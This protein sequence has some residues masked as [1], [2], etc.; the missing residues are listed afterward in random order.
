MKICVVIVPGMGLCNRLKGLLT[1]M[2]KAAITG[3]TFGLLWP[4]DA[5]VSCQF[6]DLFDMPV[7]RMDSPGSESTHITWRFWVG[8]NEIPAGWAQAYPS[9]DVDGRA[10]DFEY[11]RIPQGVRAAYLEQLMH[12]RPKV[13][14]LRRAQKTATGKFVS[15]HIRDGEDW[16]AWG[17]GVP[18]ENFFSA[19]DRCPKETRFFVSAHTLETVERIC[20]R[21]PG[22]VMF[23]E[24]KEYSG[25]TVR[26]MQDALADLLCLSGGDELIG[27]Y[28]S[29]F[30]EM[31]WWF[32]C[33][34][35]RVTIVKGDQSKFRWF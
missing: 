19:M 1:V 5:G 7:E 11:E 23:Q 28:G 8:K 9:E 18:L 24:G 25:Q 6:E 32:G 34:T 16:N 31:A 21:Y 4:T 22:R 33:C 14:I 35:Q 30:T 15:V 2:R 3:N 20:D 17:R 29:T 26:R 27:T 13:E 10:I 12:L